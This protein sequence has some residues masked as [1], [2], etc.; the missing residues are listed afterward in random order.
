MVLAHFGR[1]EPMERMRQLCG[2]ARD[3]IS[4]GALVRAAQTL[5]L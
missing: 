1:W 2:S 3:G 5:N 4:A